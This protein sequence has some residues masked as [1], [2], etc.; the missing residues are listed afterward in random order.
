MDFFEMVKRLQIEHGAKILLISCGAF[1][2]AIGADAVFLNKE[3]G[4][5]LNCAKKGICKV[6]IP[7]SSLYKYLQ[8]LDE[9]EFAY[10]V[11]DYDTQNNCLLKKIEKQGKNIEE[12]A[13][14]IECEN[15]PRRRYFIKTKY[16]EA[17]EKYLKQEFGENFE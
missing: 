12:Y 2:I 15:C 9:L 5:K 13:F 10:I 14:N 11:I 6:G 8:K 3:I 7:K 16:D 4:L 17:L 1:Y